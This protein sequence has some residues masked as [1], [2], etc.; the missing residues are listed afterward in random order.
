MFTKE[1]NN[2]KNIKGISIVNDIIRRCQVGTYSLYSWY[3]VSELPHNLYDDFSSE[4]YV[5][6]K[7]LHDCGSSG[8]VVY[9]ALFPS[10]QEIYVS[11]HKS[12]NGSMNIDELIFYEN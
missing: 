12:K 2:I 4:T 5:A 6:T 11:L 3:F 9:V 10:T 1:I 7:A 8:I